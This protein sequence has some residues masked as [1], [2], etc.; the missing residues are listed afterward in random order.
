MSYVHSHHLSS[1]ELK[2]KALTCVFVGYSNTQKRYNCYHP[3]TRR[4]IIWKDIVFDES[5]FMGKDRGNRE[6]NTKLSLRSGEGSPKLSL[7][8]F[9]LMAIFQ[10]PS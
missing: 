5:C 6:K 4:V 10:Y 2:V 1:D 7:L 3:L 9:L 8:G